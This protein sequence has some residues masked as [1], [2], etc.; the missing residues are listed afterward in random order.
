MSFY[1]T[2]QYKLL[3]PY[4]SE[5]DF[6]DSCAFGLPIFACRNYMKAWCGYVGVPKG[7][8]FFGMDYF[9]RV[10][11]DRDNL[12]IGQQSPMAIFIEAMKEDDGKVALDILLDCPGGLTWAN[13][14][15]PLG[16][17][18]KYWWFGFDCSHYNDLSPHDIISSMGESCWKL[19]TGAK[20]RDLKFVKSAL[21]KL[22]DQLSEF[23]NA[24][25]ER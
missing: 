25:Q 13:D 4:F 23:S 21:Y 3:S 9:E 7:H 24:P 8:S 20:Y 10:A 19:E 18:G 17:K 5:P 12:R 6:F 11:T 16:P 22:A 2:I 14:H 15:Q 1:D